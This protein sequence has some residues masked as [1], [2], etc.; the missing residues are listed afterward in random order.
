MTVSNSLE[1]PR[2]RNIMPGAEVS[3][4]IPILFNIKK[5]LSMINYMN[6]QIVLRQI[7][8]G[9]GLAFLVSGGSGMYFSRLLE[10][11]YNSPITLFQ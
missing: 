4:K 6:S 10:Y 8:V 7:L 11:L 9:Q 2:G 1:H 3:S 5:L